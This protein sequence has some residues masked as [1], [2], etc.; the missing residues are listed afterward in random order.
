MAESLKAAHEILKCY[1][2][3]IYVIENEMSVIFEGLLGICFKN[4]RV[5][6]IGFLFYLRSIYLLDLKRERNV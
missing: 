6:F 2:E 5:P 3:G 1:F 4:E